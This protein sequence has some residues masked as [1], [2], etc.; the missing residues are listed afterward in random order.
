MAFLREAGE[1]WI[2]GTVETELVWLHF[3]A[4]SSDMSS[5][6]AIAVGLRMRFLLDRT[7]DYSFVN[8]YMAIWD[9]R[10]LEVAVFIDD[11]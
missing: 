7:Q 1:P 8:S 4:T 5:E 6:L 10:V 2:G 11:L 9:E 3:F